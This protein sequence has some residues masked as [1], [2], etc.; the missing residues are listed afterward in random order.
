MKTKSIALLRVL[1]SAHKLGYDI[2]T[3]QGREQ[4]ADYLLAQGVSII[5][6][7]KDVE[8]AFGQHRP[9]H[10]CDIWGGDIC[11]AYDCGYCNAY[12][13]DVAEIPCECGLYDKVNSSTVAK[14]STKLDWRF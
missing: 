10:P 9:T 7:P 6:R 8:S 5:P 13:C 1:T 3:E 11:S 12:K 14:L 2:S 4:V